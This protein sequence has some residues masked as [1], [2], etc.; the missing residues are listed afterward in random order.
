MNGEIYQISKEQF[1]AMVNQPVDKN[2]T[3]AVVLSTDII[4][5]MF[6]NQPLCFIG[7]APRSLVS[8]SA[9]IWMIT[10]DEGKR[11]SILIARYAKS[12][13][14]IVMLKYS[15]IFG[16][17]FDEKSRNWLRHLGAKFTSLTQ[18]EFRRI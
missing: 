11:H 12:F 5:G 16:D 1:I 15:F 6:N 2:L 14:E 8:D 7:I 18:F 17:C 9:Y 10:T 4:V 13:V 3:E